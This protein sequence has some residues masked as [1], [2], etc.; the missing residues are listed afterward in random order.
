MQMIFNCD[1]IEFIIDPDEHQ[2]LINGKV[3][4][5]EFAPVGGVV[6]E[7]N[8][9]D[10]T[11]CKVVTDIDDTPEEKKVVYGILLEV[12]DKV[13]ILKDYI[14][15]A[16]VF[17]DKLGNG[18]ADV[19]ISGSYNDLRNK[20]SINGKTLDG[21]LDITVGGG[22]GGAIYQPGEGITISSTNVISA[23]FNKVVSKSEFTATVGDIGTALDIIN[24]ELIEIV[25]T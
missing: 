9:Q 5:G 4:A 16:N 22:G 7:V 2:I 17:F 20:P 18:F 6:V 13:L 12:K 21:N 11:L 24:S 15:P 23:D 10:D 8:A 25:N 3:A 1:G 14:I 19:A